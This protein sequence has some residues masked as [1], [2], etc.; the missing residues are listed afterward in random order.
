MKQ[1]VIMILMA[2]MLGCLGGRLYFD[3]P[4]RYDIK[5]SMLK[6]KKHYELI[7]QWVDGAQ[8]G[9]D[10]TDSIDRLHVEADFLLER[11]PDRNPVIWQ[12]TIREMQQTLNFMA[13]SLT[14][15]QRDRAAYHFRNLRDSCTDCHVRYRI[16]FNF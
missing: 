5:L 10:L 16:G 8:P 9:Q 6:M 11:L 2:A 4:T 12:E 7:Q 13:D 1:L 14:E 15:N 3:K